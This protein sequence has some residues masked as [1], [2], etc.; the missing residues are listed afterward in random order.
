[1]E[2]INT[3][4]GVKGIKLDV[5][6]PGYE[7]NFTR[8]DYSLPANNCNR[9]NDANQYFRKVWKNLLTLSK[10]KKKEC[11]KYTSPFISPNT[12]RGYHAARYEYAVKFFDLECRK[13]LD[14]GT[15]PGACAFSMLK[16]K[17]VEVTGVSLVP[18]Y[19]V[20]GNRKPVPY[21]LRDSRFRFIEADADTY[22]ISEQYDL[23]HDDVDSAGVRTDQTD[24]VNA[25]GALRRAMRA[26]T[27]VKAALMTIHDVCAEVIEEMYNCYRLYGDFDIIKP[28]YSNPWKPEYM[29][30]FR[31]SDKPRIRKVAFKRALYRFLNS[32]S[33]DIL[34]WSELLN[35]N[36]ERLA[37]GRDARRCPSQDDGALQKR[38]QDYL[39][40]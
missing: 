21:V 25:L 29:V 15:H 31:K 22:V 11:V 37:D 36:V 10:R 32:F 12:C 30:V 8:F 35:S 20:R 1:M 6:W 16:R 5:P 9:F 27:H 40:D 13:I 3:L 28:L 14:Y 34:R 18:L 38:F 4:Y 2:F 7:G 24:I 23:L 19:D 33:S 26:S 17:D 39:W